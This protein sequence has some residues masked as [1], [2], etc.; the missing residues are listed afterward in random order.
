MVCIDDLSFCLCMYCRAIQ[1]A[2]HINRKESTQ[3]KMVSFA[4]DV[5]TVRLCA[6]LSRNKNQLALIKTFLIIINS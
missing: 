3:R 5:M 1:K 2:L 6:A 4:V